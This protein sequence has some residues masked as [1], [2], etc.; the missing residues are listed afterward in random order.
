MDWLDASRIVVGD[1]HLEGVIWVSRS[2]CLRLGNVGKALGAGDQV[3]VRVAKH[4]G[5]QHF[6]DKLGER[7]GIRQTCSVASLCLAAE[8]HDG[9]SPEV[10]LL[11]DAQLAEFWN[12]QI[13]GNERARWTSR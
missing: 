1:D 12:S 9:A 11:V 2:V 7:T 5:R 6:L 3:H 13:P 10:F 4:Q 8:N